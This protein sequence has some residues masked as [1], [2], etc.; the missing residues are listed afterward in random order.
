MTWSEP[1]LRCVIGFHCVLWVLA[2]CTRRRVNAQCG[3]F[4]VVAAAVAAAERLNALGARRWSSFATQDYF[5]EHG[6]FAAC[7]WCAPLLALAFLQL[8]NFLYLASNLLVDVKRNE[9]RADMAS[10][11]KMGA[12]HATP[13]EH[14]KAD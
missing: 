14:P 13:D 7:V 10:K 6:V 4:F 5:D 12:A 11:R 1:W 8:F 3:I 9:I 2:V